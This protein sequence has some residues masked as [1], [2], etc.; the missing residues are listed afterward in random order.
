[1]AYATFNKPSLQFNTKLYTGNGGTN[2]I[3]GVGFQPDMVWIKDRT[4]TNNHEIHDVVRGVNYQIYPNLTNAQTN[5]ANH[6]TTFGTDGFTV[7]SDGALNT[8]SSNYCSWNWKAGNTQGS[9]N[10]DGSINTTYTS[11]N[12]SAGFS[13]SQYTG[14]GTNGA[15]IG[16]GLGAVP[17]TVWIKRLSNAD[18]MI[19]YHSGYGNNASV[20]MDRTDASTGNFWNSTTP[21]SSV[22]TVTNSTECN[23]NGQTYVMY[24]FA[25]KKGFSK[26]GKYVGNGNAD[27]NFI[28]TGFKSAF[29]MLKN[30]TS[31]SQ[32]MLYDNKRETDTNG[33]PNRAALM[34]D[35]N[36]AEDVNAEQLDV[37][38]NGFKC[39]T[40]GVKMND[41]S[42]TF[43]YWAF[44]AEPLVAN[45]GNNGIP[46]T[47][48]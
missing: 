48:V 10:N 28:Y 34:P 1:M 40:V 32:W 15:T 11:V 45:V 23:V 39:R 5:A 31:T 43:L 42:Q 46:A 44:A 3:T 25:P 12:T 14:N 36:N 6:L 8:N 47:A 27:G 26:F 30:I 35:L 13:I 41:S 4:G 19:V 18:A 21:T 9:A 22:V 38:S 33:N 17:E 20:K 16:H 37:L 2:A 29:V 7:G 24:A